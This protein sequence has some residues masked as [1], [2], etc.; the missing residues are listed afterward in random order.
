MQVSDY[1]R[2]IAIESNDEETDRVLK[3]RAGTSEREDDSEEISKTKLEVYNENT[4]S[5][6]SLEDSNKTV[7][8]RI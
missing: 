3:E 2:I 4:R 8:V 7:K 5:M 1:N 6:N